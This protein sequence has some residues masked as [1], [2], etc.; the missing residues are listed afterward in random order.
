[1][2][3]TFTWLGQWVDDPEQRIAALGLLCAKAVATLV[4]GWILAR[5]V[6][7][8]IKRL[9]VRAHVEVTLCGFLGNLSYGLL[10]TLVAVTTIGQL[11]VP[12]TSFVAVI[13]AAGLAIGLALQGSLSSFA[14][15]VMVIIFRPFKVGDFIEAAGVSATVEEIQI[16]ATVLRTGD[17]KRVI[18][19]NAKITSGSIINHS[20]NETRRIDLVMRMGYDDDIPKAKAL[21]QQILDADERILKDPAPTIALSEL[22]AGRASFVV[23]PWV[24][25][26]DYWGVRR[27]V[28]AAVKQSFDQHGIKIPY[29]AA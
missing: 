26:A 16:F 7:A 22:A 25:T 20:A 14:A 2:D 28:T 15:G 13:G 18:V 8:L 21:V 19:P 12:T 4:V 5:L 6:T 17:N 9:L 27:D 1:M 3:A 29:L 23:R 10:M 24:K 11:G